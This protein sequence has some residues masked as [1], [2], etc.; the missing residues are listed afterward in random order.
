MDERSERV[1]ELVIVLLEAAEREGASALRERLRELSEREPELAGRVL[2]RLRALEESGLLALPAPL[3]A[4]S[5]PEELGD[6]RLERRIAAGGMG[7]VFAAWQRSVGR[8]VALKLVR[9]EHFYFPGAR[10]RFRREVEAVARLRDPGIVAVHAVGEEQG[11]P[12]LA[13]ELVE[14][15]SLDQAIAELAG[16][17]PARLRGEELRELALR[18]AP[19]E[20]ESSGAGRAL[21]A[22]AWHEMAARLV[23]AVA[24]SVEHAHGRGVLHRDLKPS[25]VLVTPAGRAV[26]VDFGLASVAGATRLTRSGSQLG[27]LPYMAPE[28]LAGEARELLPA[29]DVYGLGV[30]L[31][32]LCTLRLPYAGASA[33]EIERAMRAA[34]PA[35][36]RRFQPGAPRDL[37]TVCAKALELEPARRYA[38][39]A[40]LAEDLRR[41]LEHRPVRARRVGLPGRVRR[42]ARRRPAAAAAL[43]LAAALLVGGPIA[44][45]AW[46]A[47]LDRREER[48]GAAQALAAAHL[49]LAL[50]TSELLLERGG[51]SSVTQLVE[52]LES[53][54]AAQAALDSE[55]DAGERGA[56][57][58]RLRR[59]VGRALV[60][61]GQRVRAGAA[62]QAQVEELRA[63]VDLGGAPSPWGFALVEALAHWS[64]DLLAGGRE[65]EA[66]AAIE[67]AGRVVEW[68]AAEPA[69]EA[70]VHTH[71]ATL[72]ADRAQALTR[73][74]RLAAAREHYERALA[75]LAAPP[76]GS[77]EPDAGA[78]ERHALILSGLGLLEI[79]AG[80]RAEALPALLDARA[81]AE[82]AL[83]LEP[84]SA[85][86]SHT[87]A[88]IAGDLG[89]AL[90]FADRHEE[91]R[92]ELSHAALLFE[93]LARAH[94][95]SPE[96]S[97]REL[98]VQDG[99]A[100]LAQR[101][102][103]VDAARA[104][105]AR[106]VE[107]VE[108][109]VARHPGEHAFLHARA[110]ALNNA[111]QLELDAERPA[112]ALALYAR[113]EAALA[114]LGPRERLGPHDRERFAWIPISSASALTRL[115]RPERA[116]E[117][118]ARA[119]ELGPRTGALWVQIA[120]E[121]CA[122][123]A[124]LPELLDERGRPWEELALQA[125]RRALELGWCDPADLESS[126]AW[127]PLRPLA[128]FDEL[129]ATARRRGPR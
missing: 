124:L 5:F 63:R 50:R 60:Q 35:S 7:V 85:S 2:A 46:S 71:C 62:H 80:R 61:L 14:G 82:E 4:D 67:E 13:M 51:E 81:L 10:E 11:L 93:Q 126:G 54:L 123:G 99:L 98:E 3:A 127:A 8:R 110:I 9:P 119:S 72:D 17:D 118:L 15:I 107:I 16:R 41:V 104:G 128:E 53:A 49:D 83:A 69:F 19:Q 84:D 109:L 70:Q 36:L 115:G 92:A 78:L 112:E 23:A 32:E 76:P 96:L 56:F 111:A 106:S 94:P 47:E 77:P 27:S 33:A 97:L 59:L 26:V 34:P 43:A 100:S 68:L 65:E 86:L 117:K 103:E 64:D 31:Y 79:Q 38:S 29:A 52:S 1:H 18:R 30:T 12:Y 122:A 74:G 88:M 25:N 21:F 73:L 24:E 116:A 90:V 105:F 66:L 114:A 89:R 101:L 125:L 45:R 75:R 20:R 28:A 44:W 37:E 48:I 58:T 42:F 57:A 121:W 91:A 102:R 113:A 22:G 40:E 95:E 87:R 129:V 55:L 120:R 6:F 108:Q 39:A